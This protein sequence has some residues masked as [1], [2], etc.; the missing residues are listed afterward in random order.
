AVTRVGSNII[1]RG[2]IEE[3]RIGEVARQFL[4]GRNRNRRSAAY[5]VLQL[6][7]G[8]EEEQPVAPVVELRNP[9]RTAKRAAV[10]I[11]SVNRRGIF[12]SA[13]GCWI[14]TAIQ[15]LLASVEPVIGIERGVAEDVIGRTMKAIA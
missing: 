1:G 2:R 6:L 11:L 9:Y 5:R 13:V 15:R 12:R 14:R 3:R 10:V 4:G 8:E 7:P